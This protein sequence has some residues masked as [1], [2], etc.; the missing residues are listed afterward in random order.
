MSGP[1]YH[2][3]MTREKHKW[4]CDPKNA[5]V[6]IDYKDLPKISKGK[7]LKVSNLR[8]GPAYMEVSSR[9]GAFN[10]EIEIS[11][12]QIMLGGDIFNA[13]SFYIKQEEFEEG[14]RVEF[15]VTLYK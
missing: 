8:G 7:R 15:D 10:K 11:K 12:N 6:I 3:K 1:S 14:E 5:D 2:V 13:F 4:P 9:S